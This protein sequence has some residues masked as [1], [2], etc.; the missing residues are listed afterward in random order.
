MNEEEIMRHM[1]S[2]E[3]LY[4]IANVVKSLVGEQDAIVNI[5]IVVPIREKKFS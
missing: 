2:D 5:N 4:F 1:E 3:F